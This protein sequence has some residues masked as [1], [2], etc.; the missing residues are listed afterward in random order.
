MNACISFFKVLIFCFIIFFFNSYTIAAAD[1]VQNSTNAQAIVIDPLSVRSLYVIENTTNIR[2]ATATGFVINKNNKSYLI[3]NWHVVTGRHP[4][5]NEIIDEKGRTPNSITIL[6][7]GKQLGTWV[8]KNEDLYDRKGT[9]RWL[10]HPRGR[11]I[12]VVALPLENIGDDI[13][14]YP[15]NLSLA[16]ADIVPEIAM[17]V[18][19][20]GFPLG[21]TGTG[22]LPIWKT[23]HIA[24][25]P[26]LDYQGEPLFL[27]DATT[28]GGMSGSPVILRMNGGY[29]TKKGNTIMSSG[30]YRTLFLGIYSGRLPR[31]SEIGKVWR[32]KLINEIIK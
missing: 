24:S 16:D 3:T 20:I 19:I 17:P 14:I 29:K 4:S 8:A 22:F 26:N 32:P 6:H 28:R 27:I 23:G 30:G 18:S 21:F 5:S 7:N 31:D 9:K 12:D 15:F 2:I 1:S 13:T 25:E 10:E 11:A